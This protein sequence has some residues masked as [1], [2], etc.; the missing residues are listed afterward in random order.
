VESVC[1]TVSSGGTESILLAMRTT[2]TGPGPSEGSPILR[3]LVL[4]APTPLSTRRLTISVSE[5]C[6]FRWAPTGA[7]DATA[8]RALVTDDTIVIVG[9]AP[10]SRTG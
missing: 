5:P 8:A 10:V 4:S 9:S 1:G 6:P 7:A 2:A 3:W